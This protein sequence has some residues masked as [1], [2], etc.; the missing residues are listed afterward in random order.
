ERPAIVKDEH[1]TYL[2]A[3]RPTAVLHL[4]PTALET[5]QEELEERSY[6]RASGSSG[7]TRSYRLRARFG[8][9]YRLES[10]PERVPLA[11]RELEDR[12]EAFAAEPQR[13]RPWARRQEG[14]RRRWIGAVRA[15]LLPVAIWPTRLIQKGPSP[16]LKAG[17]SAARD[18]RWDAAR[19]AWTEEEGR[20]G[21]WRALWNLG[22]ACEHAGDWA[23]ARGYYERAVAASPEGDDRETLG[24]YLAEV[25]RAFT[26]A[27]TAAATEP[28]RWF[29]EPVA[30]LPFSN[31]TNNVAAP[32][33]ARDLAA[34]ELRRKG[35][36]VFPPA[37]TARKVRDAGV[38]QGE[39]LK[40]VSP[41]AV[42]AAAGA[43]R[44]LTGAVLSFKELN[45]G[46]YN[47]HV[48]TASFRLLDETGRVL[49]EGPGVGFREI[50]T[51]PRDAGKMFLLGLVETAVHKVTRTY[52]E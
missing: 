35:Y 28:G 1:L 20:T 26:G 3:L 16:A 14:L 34:A 22:V 18:G 6:D 42:A 29:E 5:V 38:T 37:D 2:D 50:V 17:R 11:A 46:L 7:V 45:V 4:K 36:A 49:W 43:R 32:D 41:A 40:A 48:V 39:H 15:D 33:R 27:P 52:L 31:D 21:D 30:V 24:G 9:A 10:W 12:T 25:G 44:L 8:V 19:A 13:L 47:L 51:A 23:G